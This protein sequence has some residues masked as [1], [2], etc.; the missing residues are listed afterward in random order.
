MTSIYEDQ[1]TLFQCDDVVQVEARNRPTK[2]DLDGTGRS[3]PAR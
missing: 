3:H 2:P 1:P